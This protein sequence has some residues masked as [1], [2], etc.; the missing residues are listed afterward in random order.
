MFSSFIDTYGSSTNEFGTQISLDDIVNALTNA[1]LARQK[2]E[3]EVAKAKESQPK[4]IDL[5]RSNSTFIVVSRLFANGNVWQP[6]TPIM[7]TEDAAKHEMR[8]LKK[9]DP[10]KE[11]RISKLDWTILEYIQ[12]THTF[13]WDDEDSDVELQA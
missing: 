4:P 11:Y 6:V 8:Q 9:L 3:R 2:L 10:A 13:P 7:T 12:P 1:Q 5:N